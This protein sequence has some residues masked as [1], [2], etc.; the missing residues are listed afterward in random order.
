M[1]DS[2]YYLLCGLCVAA[3]LLGINM[4]SKVKSSVLGNGLSAAAMVFAIALIWI[5]RGGAAGIWVIIA[6]I[7]ALAAGVV[8]G[9][10]GAMKAKMID[11]PQIIALLNGLGG[12]ASALVAAV[13]AV[14]GAVSMFEGFTAGLA[15]AIG[16][17]TFTGSLIAAGKLARILDAKPKSLPNH[18]TIMTILAVVCVVG[19]GL[20]T[21]SDACGWC[22]YAYHH[23]SS[24][25]FV[26]CGRRYCRYGDQ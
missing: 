21:V 13:T 11:M 12:A 1:N 25:C 15:L 18:S 26:R 17:L 2:L 20:Q 3:V 23:L 24:E 19:V 5:T 4:M 22:G 16:A 7:V 10:Y 6:L 9:V 8:V 14:T